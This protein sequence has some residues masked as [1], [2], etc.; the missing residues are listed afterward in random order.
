MPC[1]NEIGDSVTA[2]A[3][4][5][6]KADQAHHLLISAVEELEA[7]DDWQAALDVAARFHNYSFRNVILISMGAAEQG[8][9][10]TKVA[11]YQKWKQLGRQVRKGSK[12]L[13]ILAPLTF[14]QADDD[15]EMHTYLGGFKV[16][17]VFDIS[18]T[19]GDPIPDTSDFVIPPEGEAP[20]TQPLIELAA[21][22]GFS[23]EHNLIEGDVKGYTQF[24]P[25]RIV[26]RSGLNDA[27][28]FEVLVHELGHA[29]LHNPENGDY[30]GHRGIGEVEAE[31]VAYIVS[32]VLGLDT[33]SAS[34]GYIAGWA[35]DTDKT[36]AQVILEVGDRVLN[37]AHRILDVYKEVTT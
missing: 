35:T 36:A 5:R 19:D 33:G 8:F 37:A 11:G 4:T 15:G 27:H 10:A 31:S 16:V 30:P 6:N 20:D 2:T 21:S 26:V 7:N 14:R 17:Y 9:T 1:V 13:P 32:S 22:I 34:F 24:K 25:Q 18:Q 28:E 29:M 23:I 3:Y 12:G